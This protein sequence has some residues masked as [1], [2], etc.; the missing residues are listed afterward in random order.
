MYRVHLRSIH[1]DSGSLAF[2][3]V[4]GV[5][6]RFHSYAALR[7]AIHAAHRRATPS[8]Q[9]VR[10]TRLAPCRSKRTLKLMSSPSDRS[11]AT[12]GQKSEP[13]RRVTGSRHSYQLKNAVPDPK[14][15]NLVSPENLIKIDHLPAPH[16]RIAGSIN[17]GGHSGRERLRGQSPDGG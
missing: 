4:L 9:P 2:F 15:T 7:R 5:L 17:V 11:L 8:D 16:V 14:A 6:W 13:V 1:S 3:G 10:I 12:S